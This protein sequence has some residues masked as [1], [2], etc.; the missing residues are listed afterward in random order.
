[1]CRG[2]PEALSFDRV[3]SGGAC[4][5]SLNSVLNILSV[6]LQAYSQAEAS[7]DINVISHA[8]FAIS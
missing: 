1:M 5:V 4:P 6:Q 3:I 7:A 8:P 2:I